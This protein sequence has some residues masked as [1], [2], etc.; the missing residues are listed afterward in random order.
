M[1]FAS[2][3]SIGLWS[4]I[5]VMLLLLFSLPVTGQGGTSVS[6][7]NIEALS[8]ELPSS[9]LPPQGMIANETLG[10]FIGRILQFL[11][12]VGVA[13]DKLRFRQHMS[14]E[15]AHYAKDCWDAECHTSY[16]CTYIDTRY[17]TVWMGGC[18]QRPGRLPQVQQIDCWGEE[19]EF[20]SPVL[21][22]CRTLWS[23]HLH[24]SSIH[25]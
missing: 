5:V 17:I 24:T 9:S 15:M 20:V 10:Y 11:I 4:I 1:Y 12:K 3:A 22:L 19:V 16:V 25:V 8:G 18:G 2:E 7:A 23:I 6:V 21:G 13:P 14:N